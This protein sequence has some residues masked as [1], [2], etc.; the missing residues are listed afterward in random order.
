MG[1]DIWN[2][3]KSSYQLFKI[4]EG[5][6]ALP[7]TWCIKTV[8]LVCTHTLGRFKLHSSEQLWCL[9][10]KAFVIQVN[11]TTERN[12]RSIK[13]YVCVRLLWLQYCQDVLK[14][15]IL[16]HL[17]N[18]LKR[19]SVVVQLF[20]SSFSSPSSSELKTSCSSSYFRSCTFLRRI[21]A[22]V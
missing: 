8:L 18:V 1:Y 11:T 16:T 3:A 2:L 12:L 6:G 9:E 10:L 14:R 4:V 21:C 13:H 22:Q 19:D 7:L 20:I 5:V 15:S 17:P